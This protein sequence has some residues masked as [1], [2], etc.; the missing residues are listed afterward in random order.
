[1]SWNFK[2]E[3]EKES[4]FL[5]TGIAIAFGQKFT[6]CFFAEFSILLESDTAQEMRGLL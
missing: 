2:I 3:K 4:A 5:L 6:C 1:M